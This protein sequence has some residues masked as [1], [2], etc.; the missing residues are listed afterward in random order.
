M[1]DEDETIKQYF[2]TNTNFTEETW[3]RIEDKE[4]YMTSTQMKEYGLIDEII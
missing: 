2:L 1:Y 3:A 4:F